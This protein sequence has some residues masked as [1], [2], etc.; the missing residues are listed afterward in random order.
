MFEGQF[1]QNLEGQIK[2]KEFKEIFE[3]LRSQNPIFEKYPDLEDL[4][5]LLK[6]SNKN[7]QDKDDIMTLLLQ[8]LKNGNEIYPLI[9]MMFWKS[10]IRLYRNRYNRV[11]DKEALFSRL[12][13]DFYQSVI[14]HNLER[15]PRKIDVNIFLNT[16]KKVIAWEKE[17]IRYKEILKELG[18]V[19][20]GGYLADDMNRSTVYQEEMEE[21]LLDLLYRQVI[22]KAQYDLIIETKVLRIKSPKQW[23]EANNVSYN[24]VRSL[25]H[26]AKIAIKNYEKSREIQ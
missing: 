12:Q 10:L 15:L 8:E 26:R 18:E 16:K 4:C 11:G 24:T 1:R 14:N 19:Y 20:Q 9:N 22:T 7:Y 25:N 2:S 17:T 6:P 13:W 23:A 5:D 3:K 21:Y